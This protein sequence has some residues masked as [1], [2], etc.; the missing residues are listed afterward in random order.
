M[1]QN[2]IEI[3]QDLAFK[4]LDVLR[5][6]PIY[7]LMG[8]EFEAELGE[9][10]KPHKWKGFEEEHATAALETYRSLLNEME[11]QVRRA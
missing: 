1:S 4:I 3:D 2:R 6:T 11:G 9:D 8:S 10:F 5:L 7:A